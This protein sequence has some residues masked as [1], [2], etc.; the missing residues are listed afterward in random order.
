MKLKGDNDDNGVFPLRAGPISPPERELR[1]WLT[2][3]LFETRDDLAAGKI[4]AQEANDRLRAAKT[5]MT[6][7][8]D[9]TLASAREKLER[10]FHGS[11]GIT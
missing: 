3:K 9:D 7:L 5:V 4:T 11:P 2:Q 6:G 10:L 8:D 1:A